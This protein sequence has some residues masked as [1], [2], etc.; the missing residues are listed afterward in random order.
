M[1]HK[2]NFATVNLTLKNICENEDH[3]FGGIP[4]ILGGDSAQTFLVVPRGSRGTQCNASISHSTL[5]SQL[6][7]LHLKINM[8]V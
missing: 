7:V 6:K 8:R 1:Q 5:W 3:L 2:E 4:V